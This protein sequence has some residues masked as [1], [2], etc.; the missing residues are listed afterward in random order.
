MSRVQ[1]HSV[2]RGFY[3]PLR[4]DAGANFNLNHRMSDF[5]TKSD[6]AKMVGVS[7]RTVENWGK[8]GILSPLKIGGIVRY[9]RQDVEDA[10]AAFIIN[11][12]STKPGHTGKD[13]TE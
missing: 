11:R 4:V 9:R 13:H 7:V 1:T 10:L 8:N 3:A 12:R 2:P 6:V 5:M